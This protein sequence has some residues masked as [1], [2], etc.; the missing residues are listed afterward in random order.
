MKSCLIIL[1][2]FLFLSLNCSKKQ[3][4]HPTGT[5]CPDWVEARLENNTGTDCCYWGLRLDNGQYLDP[6]NLTDFNI[7]LVS[8]KKVAVSFTEITDSANCC[9]MGR[10]IKIQCIK[11]TN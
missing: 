6:D 4:C 9:I 1:T 10:M 2:G 8:G 11:D 5:G 7:E 3:D